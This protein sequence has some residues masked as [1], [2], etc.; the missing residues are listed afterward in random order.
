MGFYKVDC[1]KDISYM[2]SVMNPLTTIL[3][4]ASNVNVVPIDLVV[5]A[6]MSNI[7]QLAKQADGQVIHTDIFPSVGD[8][9][10]RF[11]FLV[12]DITG[13]KAVL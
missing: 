4:K 11:D 7:A 1:M 8:Y 12:H 6:G 10:W 9:T 5:D 3:D 2:Q 13:W